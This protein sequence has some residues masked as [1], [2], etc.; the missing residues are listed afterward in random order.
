MTDDHYEAPTKLTWGKFERYSSTMLATD[1]W[2]IGSIADGSCFFHS[3]LTAINKSYR[4]INS[5]ADRILK[6]TEVR[7]A[8]ARKITRTSWEKLQNGE[9]AHFSLLEKISEYETVITK[10]LKKHSRYKSSKSRAWILKAIKYDKSYEIINQVLGNNLIDM[11]NFSKDCSKSSGGYIPMSDCRNIFVKHQLKRYVQGIEKQLNR[12]TKNC[13]SGDIEASVL[14]YKEL[15][16]QFFNNASD[17]ALSKLI[18]YFSDPTEWIGTEYLSFLGNQFNINIL[19]VDGKTGLPYIQGDDSSIKN[20][21]SS[22]VLLNVDEC[23][24]ETLGFEIENQNNKP[25]IKCRL[26]W[27]HP[28]IQKIVSLSNKS[29]KT[30]DP[31][32]DKIFGQDET[33]DETDDNEEINEEVE[34]KQDETTIVSDREETEFSNSDSDGDEEMQE[35]VSDDD[36]GDSSSEDDS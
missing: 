21:R 6:V 36:S 26:P 1:V 9:P 22:I 25:K 2:R 24:Y 31:L 12:L 18:T 30:E 17:A 8:I 4:N 13:E 34:M 27:T 10:V 19:I 33:V 35:N 28:M 7:N 20:G 5:R 16:K 3:I 15:L 11:S 29:T 14:D 32:H 23:H